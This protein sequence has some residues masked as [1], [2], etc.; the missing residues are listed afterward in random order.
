MGLWWIGHGCT[1]FVQ[2]N[3]L[4][5]FGC[6]RR[7]LIFLRESVFTSVSSFILRKYH[8]GILECTFIKV[9]PV[10]DFA[11][12]S[13]VTYGLHNIKYLSLGSQITLF[14]VKKFKIR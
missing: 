6:S 2:F 7:Q 4:F 13:F 3:L 11:F 8:N 12:S 5:C 1:P 14:I 10:N 9:L